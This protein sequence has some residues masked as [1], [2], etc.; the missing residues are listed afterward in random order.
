YYVKLEEAP[1]GSFLKYSSQ[2]V[3]KPVFTNR[4]DEHGYMYMKIVRLL[5]EHPLVMLDDDDDDDD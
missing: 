2:G 1:S 4:I 5:K 3:G